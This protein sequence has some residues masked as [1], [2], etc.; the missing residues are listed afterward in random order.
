LIPETVSKFNE[1]DHYLF[2]H[3]SEVREFFSNGSVATYIVNDGTVAQGIP[4]TTID[5]GGQVVLYT[6]L[7]KFLPNGAVILVKQE[8]FGESN[9]IQLQNDSF[10]VQ[11]NNL[12]VNIDLLNWQYPVT[13]PVEVEMFLDLSDNVTSITPG[14]ENN[15]NQN[16]S[17]INSTTF[18]TA[19][20]TVTLA[21]LNFFI[22]PEIGQSQN[23]VSVPL[24][25]RTNFSVG[26]NIQTL[27]FVFAGWNSSA[28][29]DPQ[30]G[31]LLGGAAPGTE[32]S[33]GSSLLLILLTSILI[34]IAVLVVLLV[35]IVGVIVGSIIALKW[36]LMHRRMEGNI[37][38]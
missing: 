29:Y 25:V 7:R 34:P 4:V 30:V 28:L 12:K 31:I 13:G 19:N 1:T 2:L 11:E 35:I 20:T 3:V 32:S 22:T 10:V 36:Y 27:V 8:L 17:V 6:D 9:I 33:G 26:T 24:T 38:I 5:N 16:N 37:S 15:P 18:F 14:I 23:Y 21:L